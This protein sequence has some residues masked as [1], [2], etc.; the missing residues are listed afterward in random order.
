MGT[1]GKI[2]LEPTYDAIKKFR[3][4]HAIVRSG[5]QWGMIDK[6]GKLIIPVE[7]DEIGNTFNASGVFGIKG[8]SYGIIHNGTFKSIEGA[9]KVWNFKGDSGL[10]YARKGKKVGFVNSKGEWVIEPKYDKVKSFS[11]GLAPVAIGKKWGYINPKGETVIDLQYRDAEVFSNDG[12]APVK[13]KQ[14]GFI[15][16][17]G[18]LIIPM[19][20]GISAGF[21]FLSSNNTVG[22]INGIARLKSKKGWGF[23]NNKGELLGD[24]WYENAEP[25]VKN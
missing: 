24:K 7:Y 22:F 25:F 13:E 14:W 17:T 5:E 23:F 21:A 15:N 10:T 9:D 19:E 3:N 6:T 2:I 20:Y 18:N 16:K 1:D 8:E 12:L 4:D 11:N